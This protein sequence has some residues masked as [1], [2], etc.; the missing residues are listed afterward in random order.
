MLT[1]T[2]IH[3]SRCR[4]RWCPSWRLTYPTFIACATDSQI[5]GCK[6]SSVVALSKLIYPMLHPLHT[7]QHRAHAMQYT[8]QVPTAD[9]HPRC[10]QCVWTLHVSNVDVT[11][12][13]GH[14]R[15]ALVLPWHARVWN[16]RR[17]SEHVLVT[18]TGRQQAAQWDAVLSCAVL[19]PAPLVP[20]DYHMGIYG[21]F[22]TCAGRCRRWRTPCYSLQYKSDN[23]RTPHEHNTCDWWKKWDLHNA[24]SL[25]IEYVAST[26]A[27]PCFHQLMYLPGL[28]TA[29]H[30]ISKMCKRNPATACTNWRAID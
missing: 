16:S 25:R 30:C 17:R 29:R 2:R 27:T 13:A 24:R 5:I 12:N 10:D 26:L 18:L 21:V 8:E 28:R 14:Y 20:V 3:K 11:L 23:S 22:Y 9:N 1:K 19:D 15:H 7:C 4:H 6:P